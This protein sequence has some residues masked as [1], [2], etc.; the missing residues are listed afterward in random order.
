MKE[1]ILQHLRCPWDVRWYDTIDS[2]NTEAK[3]LAR[4][5]APHGTVLIAGHQ[6]DGRGRMG[7][8]FVSDAD[9]GVYL[10]VILR[11]CCEP[12]ELMHL[13]CAAAV[14]MCDA[15]EKIAGFRPGAKW[16][17]DLVYDG[18][19][20][21]GILTEMSLDKGGIDYAI[22]GIGINCSQTVTDFPAPLQ[23]MAGS[24]SMVT[25]KPVDRA[26]LAA[27]MTDA[28]HEMDAHLPEKASILDR[29]RTD[30][31]TLGKDVIT[32]PTRRS[33]ARL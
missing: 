3:R 8:Q 2:T 25:G 1:R 23:D 17:N 19:K 32:I 22:V 31:I 11:P 15:V 13:T 4:Q 21:G 10:S 28:L 26:K 24:L 18:R 12:A 5:G 30:C 6:T 20:L 16:I 29:Y 27:A 7:R 14:A 33:G 9:M